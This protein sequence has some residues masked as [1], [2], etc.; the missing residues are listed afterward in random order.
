MDRL[1]QP[2]LSFEDEGEEV[3][4]EFKVNEVDHKPEYD[5]KKYSS[6]SRR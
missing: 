1:I 2:Y 3:H 4:E 6:N 5:I